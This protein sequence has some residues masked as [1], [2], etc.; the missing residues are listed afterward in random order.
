MVEYDDKGRPIAEPQA[1]PRYEHPEATGRVQMIARRE[2]ESVA[3]SFEKVVKRFR[4]WTLIIIAVAS[5][6]YAVANYASK[7]ADVAEVSVLRGEIQATQRRVDVL[8]QYLKDISDDVHVIKIQIL[9]GRNV[10]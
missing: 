4:F 8:E 10:P 9:K 2:A 5:T 6:G 3:G 7:K 1:V